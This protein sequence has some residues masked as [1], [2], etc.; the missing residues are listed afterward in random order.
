MFSC[1]NTLRGTSVELRD[2]SQL[3]VMERGRWRINLNS[4]KQGVQLDEFK[5]ICSICLS[6]SSLQRY[7][8]PKTGQQSKLIAVCLCSGLRPFVHKRCIENW[9]EV[10]GCTSC[11]FC[12]VRYDLTARR[13]SI[14]AYIREL[15]LERELIIGISALALSLYLFLLGF[16]ICYDFIYH[17]AHYNRLL[18]IVKIQSEL[19]ER[20]LGNCTWAL[21][22][23]LGLPKWLLFCITCILTALF[24]MIIVY[25]ML[26]LLIRLFLRYRFCSFILKFLSN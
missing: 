22:A 21:R 10:S 9:I 7:G 3:S 1:T 8:E 23:E 18:R 11:P 13:K 4:S 5:N 16:S 20:T 25:T 2:T 6:E 19:I 17:D 14:I 26:N 12:L 24:L 15:H